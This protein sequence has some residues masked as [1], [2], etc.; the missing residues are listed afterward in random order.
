MSWCPRGATKNLES[1]GWK[2]P[3]RRAAFSLACIRDGDA[4]STHLP[5][6]LLRIIYLRQEGILD[7]GVTQVLH[8]EGPS[9]W[10]KAILLPS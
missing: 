4:K 8:S 9:A 10:F 1:S 3:V 6:Y 7:P 2:W 5:I